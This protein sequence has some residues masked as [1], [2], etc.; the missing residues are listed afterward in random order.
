M[1]SSPICPTPLYKLLFRLMARPSFA[2]D[3][4]ASQSIPNR[5]CICSSV[6][7]FV[8]ELLVFAAPNS[9]RKV[10]ARKL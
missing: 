10:L 4:C 7:P 3:V 2:N 6:I 5:R 8:E 9:S 1:R